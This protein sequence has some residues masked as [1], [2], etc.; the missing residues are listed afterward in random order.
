MSLRPAAFLDRDGT[1]IE[2]AHYLADP[3]GVVLLPGAAAAIRELNDAGVAVVVVTNQAGIARGKFG[4]R[5]Y[6]LVRDRVNELLLAE[7]ARADETLHCPHHPDF[8][9][10]C[11][12]RKPGTKLHREAIARLGLD[13]ARA[14]FVGDRLHDIVPARTLGGRG[15]LIAGP[16][17]PAGEREAAEREFAVVRSLA[18]AVR[19]WLSGDGP[20]H[21]GARVQS[22]DSRPG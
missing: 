7:G 18:E 22:A 2:D 4:E 5:E 3:A 15:C 1:I 13:P 6:E 11:E 16:D 10:P 21:G 9:G 19:G 20:R 12:C 17:T 8:G 14:L